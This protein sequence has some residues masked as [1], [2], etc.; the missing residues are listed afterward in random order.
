MTNEGK[1]S[2]KMVWYEKLKTT[3]WYSTVSKTK[4]HPRLHLSP[5][6]PHSSLTI[7]DNTQKASQKVNTEHAEGTTASTAP[8]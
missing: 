2:K 3:R 1:T 8:I 6:C 4:Q 7:H 5:A